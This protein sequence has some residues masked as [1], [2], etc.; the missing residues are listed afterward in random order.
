MA[1]SPPSLVG[2]SDGPHHR[3]RLTSR[4]TGFRLQGSR[5]RTSSFLDHHGAW[6]LRGRTGRGAGDPLAIGSLPCL[7]TTY[8]PPRRP[9]S[10]CRS[11]GC[12]TATSWSTTTSGCG[13]RSD[14]EV[15]AHL[16][17][18]NAWTDAS[19][20]HLDGLRGHDLRGD[21]G[22]DQADRPLGAL[23][24]DAPRCG[25]HRR[26]GGGTTR[27]PSRGRSTRCAA[28]SR[29]AQDRGGPHAAG[30][31]GRDRR[32]AGA[33]RRQRRGG[34]A[35]VLLPGWVRPQPC[36]HGAGLRRRRHAAPSATRCAF[37]P[38]RPASR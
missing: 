6:S 8:R 9:P 12:T 16:E 17:A 3:A 36:R 11:S 18:E 13:R 1:T 15:I 4:A 32:R 26:A 29:R 38:S 24:R 2:H 25:R 20:R 7:T 37:A 28:G 10:G 22:P 23:T 21:Q 19:T 31:L 30:H 34:G 35:R 14:P 5:D 33:A 27:A